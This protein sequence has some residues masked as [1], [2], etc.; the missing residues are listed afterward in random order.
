MVTKDQ[1]YS[2]VSLRIIAFAFLTSVFTVFSGISD[3]QNI[4]GHGNIL[5]EGVEFLGNHKI[6][7]FAVIAILLATTLTKWFA[8]S[9]NSSSLET[10]SLILIIIS[11]IVSL[12]QGKSGGELVYKYSAGIN[13]KIV[14]QRV[15]EQK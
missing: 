8:I 2:K 6:L 9:K 11:L 12:Y 10:I 3:A 5:K 13:N 7:G 15:N 4:I 1:S 14:I